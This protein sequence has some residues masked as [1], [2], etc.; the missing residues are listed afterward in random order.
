MKPYEEIL[1]LFINP[2]EIR[3]WLQKP[4]I[5]NN[6]IIASDGFIL[7]SFDKKNISNTDQISVYPGEKLNGVYPLKH[8]MKQTISVDL[9]KDCLKKVPSV[10]VF[11]TTNKTTQCVECN[12]DGRVIFT[13][14]ADSKPREYELKGDCP[15]CDGSG[16]EVENISTPTG[17]KRL[18]YNYFGIIGESKFK[19]IKLQT[20]V[21]V[22]E[23]LNEKSFNLVF[24]NHE[25]GSSFFL[26]KDVELVMMPDIVIG[27]D[28]DEL[29]A[30]TIPLNN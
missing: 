28:D 13:Y 8:T 11:E 7:C 4:F 18:D 21:E 26:I 16:D 5:I 3:D 19:A 14:Y 27:D 25:N 15:I 6:K 17:K 29:V 1:K 30:F 10:D 12:G 23:L 2:S 24:Q 22:A 9:L 20:I